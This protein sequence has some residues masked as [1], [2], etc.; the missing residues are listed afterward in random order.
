MTTNLGHQERPSLLPNASSSKSDGTETARQSRQASE[1]SCFLYIGP[2]GVLT[3]GELASFLA[4]G[5]GEHPS[6]GFSAHHPLPSPSP[7]QEQNLTKH[8]EKQVCHKKP[9]RSPINTRALSN[10]TLS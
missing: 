8:P 10:R 6:C 5:T 2:V 9:Q 1:N 4:G 7:A 3:S